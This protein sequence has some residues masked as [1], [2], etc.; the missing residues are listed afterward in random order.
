MGFDSSPGD[1]TEL[2]PLFSGDSRVAEAASI[3]QKLRTLASPTLTATCVLLNAS[4]I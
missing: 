3:A 1:L 2:S 4:Q